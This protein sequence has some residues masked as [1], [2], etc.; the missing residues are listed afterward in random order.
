LH[1]DHTTSR[2]WFHKDDGRETGT[3]HGRGKRLIIINAGS[4]DGWVPGAELIFTGDDKQAD[5]H[6]NMDSALKEYGP[7]RINMDNAKYHKKKENH[8]TLSGTRKAELL[9]YLRSRGVDIPKTM[10]DER[11]WTV[12]LK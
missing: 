7:C 1:E 2:S 10:E 9:E 4:A 11:K 3:P 5:Y 6:G 8:I 12:Q